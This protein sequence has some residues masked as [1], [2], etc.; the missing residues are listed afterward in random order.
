M[1]AKLCSF[2]SR[3]GVFTPEECS[4]IVEI[5]GT[6]G[7]RAAKTDKDGPG[8]AVHL[9]QRH[10]DIQWVPPSTQGWDWVFARIEEHARALNS[11]AWNFDVGPPDAIQYTQYR[12]AQFYA[13]HFDNGSKATEHRKLSVTVQ[14]SPPGEYVGGRLSFWSMNA[15]RTAPLEQGAMTVFPSYLMHVARP[16]WWGTRR[17]L[18]SWLSG[19]ERLK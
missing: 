13:A 12:F 16:V 11:E 7:V 9:S 14:L 17:C 2:S 18:V 1:S 15:P 19:P 5:A 10:C 4:R 3:A 6:L 8:S